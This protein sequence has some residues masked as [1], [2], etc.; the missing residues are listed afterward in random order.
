MQSD[1]QDK[2][3]FDRRFILY[4]MCF[5]LSQMLTLLMI[6]AAVFPLIIDETNPHFAFFQSEQGAAVTAMIWFGCLLSIGLT[7]LFQLCTLKVSIA[8]WWRMKPRSGSFLLA[9]LASQVLLALPVV[10]WLWLPAYFFWVRKLGHIPPPPV[11]Q[12][13]ARGLIDPKANQK[14]KTTVKKSVKDWTG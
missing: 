14:G 5:Y 8:R 9:S 13:Q 12:A 2:K 3:E 7:L 10:A 6:G 1:L 4:G 11:N